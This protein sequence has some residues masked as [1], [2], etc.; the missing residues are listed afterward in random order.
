M[1]SS[2]KIVCLSHLSLTYLSLQILSK[3]ESKKVLEITKNSWLIVL[4][5]SIAICYGIN[6]PCC[7]F[8]PYFH[9]NISFLSLYLLEQHT[10]CGWSDNTDVVVKEVSSTATII[11]NM[12]NYE[13]YLL[14]PTISNP[15]RISTWSSNQLIQYPFTKAILW[16]GKEDNH[17]IWQYEGDS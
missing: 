12:H 13:A 16:R 7:L 17:T 9:V 1:K 2:R 4:L 10:I 15:P 8:F 14:S 5:W 11:T 3:I 6:L